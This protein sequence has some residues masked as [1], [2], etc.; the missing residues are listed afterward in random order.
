MEASEAKASVFRDGSRY[1]S[2]DIWL[3]GSLLDRE[4]VQIVIENSCFSISLMQPVLTSVLQLPLMGRKMEVE[5]EM[6][7]G[8]SV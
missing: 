3:S 7:T 1:R 2:R 6:A 5:D 4:F 8:C